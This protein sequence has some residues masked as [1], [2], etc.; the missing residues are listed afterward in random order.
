MRT[1]RNLKH[2]KRINFHCNFYCGIP[3]WSGKGAVTFWPSKKPHRLILWQITDALKF[4]SDRPSGNSFVSTTGLRF[5][6]YWVRLKVLSSW[7]R[8]CFLPFYSF[9]H[10]LEYI[11]HLRCGIPQ[12]GATTKTN[13]FRCWAHSKIP[14]HMLRS[15]LSTVLEYIHYVSSF[16]GAVVEYASSRAEFRWS[17]KG[18][19]LRFLDL[20]TLNVTSISKAF[21][22]PLVPDTL[23]RW[24]WIAA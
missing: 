9:P 3:R 13:D 5:V 23:N 21:V 4:I 17:S 18:L 22:A 20:A 11:E 8:F 1:K 6:W 24:R 10:F 14:F 2:S 12:K 15:F 16:V 7:G 19:E